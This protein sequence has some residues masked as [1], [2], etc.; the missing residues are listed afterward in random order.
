M[1]FALAV[2]PVP[3]ITFTVVPVLVN[4]VPDVSNFVANCV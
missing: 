4:P 3:P 1:S 2:I